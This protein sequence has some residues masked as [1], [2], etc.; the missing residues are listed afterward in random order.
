[1]VGKI[2]RSAHERADAL[3]R[4]P[5]HIRDTVANGVCVGR[6]QVTN[7][8]SQTLGDEPADAV[9]HILHVVL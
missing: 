8:P 4:L 2:M 7:G 3:R 9:E 1:M 6:N 5:G